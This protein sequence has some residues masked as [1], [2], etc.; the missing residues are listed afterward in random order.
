MAGKNASPLAQDDSA[1]PAAAQNKTPS[2][3]SLTRTVALVGLMGAGKSVIGRRLASALKAR[4][5]DADD[6]IERAAGMKIPEI[7]ESFGEPYFREGERRVIARLLSDPPHVL[8]TGGGA[9]M[10]AE[11]RAHMH[12]NAVTVW[13]K[14]DLDTLTKRC[15]KRNSRPLL[16]KGS[17]RETLG[18]LIQ[19]RYPVYGDA[20]VTVESRDE[21]HAE[22]V[23]RVVEALRAQGV[24]VASEDPSGNAA[25]PA[26]PGGPE[27]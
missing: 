3:S 1:S 10:D 4:F 27:A 24:L 9:Y 22:I 6:E 21:P 11:T 13:L 19:E 2:A 12:E 7:F 14:A 20:D 5:R 8:A 17:V 16:K 26:K 23:Q 18:R 25:D 15:E